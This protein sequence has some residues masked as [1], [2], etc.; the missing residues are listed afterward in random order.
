MR[1]TLPPHSI[2]KYTFS[3]YNEYDFGICHHN[4]NVAIHNDIQHR[5][6]FD[7]DGVWVGG[8]VQVV[9]HGFGCFYTFFFMLYTFVS[10]W[11]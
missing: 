8:H 5:N 9:N 7:G 10:Y 11:V 3:Y 6:I 4:A 1:Q 2:R